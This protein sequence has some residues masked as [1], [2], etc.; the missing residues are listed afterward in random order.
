MQSVGLGERLTK[1]FAVLAFASLSVTGCSLFDQPA[2]PPRADEPVKADPVLVP[3]GSAEENQPFFSKTL[4]D[5]AT[6]NDAMSRSALLEALAEAGFLAEDTEVSADSEGLGKPTPSYFVGVKMDA[7]CLI[8]QVQR[9][10]GE[11]HTTVQPAVGPD[12]NVC[13]IQNPAT[14]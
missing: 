6:G 14:D 8:G 7:E 4:Q 10:D 1:A 5:W 9:D 11:V 3:G 12:K 13:I 2:E